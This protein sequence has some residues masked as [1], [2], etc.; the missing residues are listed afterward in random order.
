MR[1]RELRRL[2]AGLL[3]TTALL[4]AGCGGDDGDES[5]A[6]EAAT[7]AESGGGT[8]AGADGDCV[9][10][11]NEG[12]SEGLKGIAAL[13]NDPGIETQVGDYGGEPFT[14]E[15]FDATT[16]GTGQQIDVAQGDCVVT[17]F[18]DEFGMPLF[19]F[20]QTADGTW[21]RISETGQHPLAADSSGLLESPTAAEVG[22]GGDLEAAG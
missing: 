10:A 20:V 13:S 22:E 2:A 12:A 3:A 16:T 5:G 18:S 14:A 6:T 8:T 21:H 7:E 11:W 17:E 9:A 1:D 19:V 4:L 15:V